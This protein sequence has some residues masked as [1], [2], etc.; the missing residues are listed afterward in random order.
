MTNVIR[1]AEATHLQITVRVHEGVFEAV[2]AD[3]G[4]G[5][6]LDETRQSS[7]LRLRNLQQR[8]LIYNGRIT[9]DTKPGDGTRVTLTIPT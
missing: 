5:F 8:T 6:N 2:I 9:F 3:D 4:K 7:G 1:H